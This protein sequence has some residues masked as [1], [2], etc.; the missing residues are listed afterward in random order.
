LGLP[1]I[2]C[3]IG[4]I[5]MIWNIAEGADRILIYKIFF[6]ILAVLIVYAV[7]WTKFVKKIPMFKGASLDDVL[8]SEHMPH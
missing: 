2:I 3:I 8:Y 6:I 7:V 1:Q 5:F 4:D